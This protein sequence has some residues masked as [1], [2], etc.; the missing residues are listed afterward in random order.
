M[1]DL[2]LRAALLTFRRKLKPAYP[3]HVTAIG[4]NASVQD[5]E[6]AIIA[7]QANV[8]EWERSVFHTMAF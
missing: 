4:K 8:P 7:K 5:S 6:A 3:T 1:L 2:S